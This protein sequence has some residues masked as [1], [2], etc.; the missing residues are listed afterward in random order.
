MPDPDPLPSFKTP[1]GSA[2]PPSGARTDAVPP[3]P[4]PDHTLLRRIG[5]GSYGEVWL[6]RNVLGVYRA[7]KIIHRSSFDHD[8]PFERE[9]AGMQR[10]E[11]VSRSHESQLNILHVGRSPGC[12]YYVMELADDMG[13]GTAID[14]GSYTP[15]NLRSELLLHG[16]LPVDECVRL[17]LALTTALEHLHR[18]G[19]VHRDIKPS[20]IV[21]VNGIPKLAD[22]G[23]VAQAEATMSFVGTE[24]YLPPEGP[25]TVQADVFSLGK[26]LYEIST[27]R[28]RQQFPELPTGITELPD[29]AA[30]AEFNEVLLRAC[31]PDVKQRYE[32]A[33]EMHADLALLQ[34]GKSVARLR[35]V[36]RRLK[37]VGRAGA[38]LAGLAV[39]AGAAFFYQQVQ[40]REARRLASENQALAEENRNRIVR[41][42]IANGVRVL[43][44]GD[45]AG[46]LL[47]FADALPLLANKPAEESIHRIRIQQALNQTPRVLRVFPHESSVYS[48]AFSPEGR[49]VATGTRDGKLRVWNAAEGSLVWG[50]KAMGGR[51][52]FVRFSRDGKRLFASS[53]IE[54][55]AFNGGVGSRNFHAVL[56][57][58]SGREVLPSHEG[59]SGI[60][61][62]VICSHFS[63]DDRWLATAQKDNRIRVFDLADGRLV[64]ELRGH[65]DEVRFLS[66]SA[67]GSLLASASLDRTVRLWRLPSGEPVGLPLAHRM[68]VVRA[69]LAGDGRHIITGSFASPGAFEFATSQAGEGEIQAWDL[70]T[71]QRVGEP[72]KARNWMMMFVNPAQPGRFYAKKH[73]YDF[74]SP[75]EPLFKNPME[76]GAIQSWAFSRDNSRVALGESRNAARIFDATTGQLVAGPFPHAGEVSAIQFSP[77]EKLLL[78]ACGDG[79]A[80]LWDLRPAPTESA[81]R[82]LPAPMQR[83]EAVI[84][85][86]QVGRSPGRTPI[87]MAEEHGPWLFDDQLEPT[88]RL[89]TSEPAMKFRDI[90]S[91]WNS[92]FWISWRFEPDS[93]ALV[94]YRP[95][96]NDL[97]TALLE[98]PDEVTANVL[99]RDDRFI[100]TGCRDGII[101]YWRTSDGGVEKSVA[102]PDAGNGRVHGI[103]PDGRTAI[104][105][106]QNLDERPVF[107]I[108]DLESG[109]FVGAP[110]ALPKGAMLQMRYAPDGKQFAIW[111]FMGAVT[112]METRTGQVI[113]SSIQHSGNLSW[114]EWD[115]DCRRL[116]TA[117]QN[118]EVLVWDVRTGAQLLGPLRTPGGIIRIARWSPD[119][120]FIVTRSDDKKVRVWDA[121]T[122][123]A[124]TPLLRHSGDVAFAFLSR[125]NRLITATHP[126]L[127]RAWDLKESPLSPG[128]LADCAKLLSGR[129]LSVAGTMLV[130]KPEEL[131]EL[132]RSL[133][134]RAPQLFE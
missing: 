63:P 88:L 53:T 128:V 132:N 21:F 61:T 17:G 30:L 45:P 49:F 70:A 95:M 116:L 56:E 111:E 97:R 92:N 60:S 10:F 91:A 38:V 23:L 122:D 102:I 24:G 78:T 13:R 15:R 80:R 98:H 58:E 133:R 55:W 130:L 94:L 19:L 6:A 40:T 71:G 131:A 118:E 18:H 126:D 99:T 120:R 77:D 34:S 33:A 1:W 113:S 25:G 89:E 8:R 84:L 44:E 108:V 81:R 124:V 127:L 125:S 43:D 20:N 100:I 4:I 52:G 65:T 96:G 29:R 104:W 79:N 121:A 86:L 64:S 5:K 117:G 73:A 112:V 123:E 109:K 2:T 68:P 119:G 50:P 9:L 72:I 31:A 114:I 103:C 129:R 42:D 41:L 14:E 67:D 51:V 85:G 69:L 105:V 93:K 46:A 28:D 3:I 87:F 26:V 27:G 110:R 11:P 75:A 37:F 90:R 59:D 54:Q 83:I 32:T 82:T 22:I 16:R 35:T 62:N 12:F 107:R 106:P 7:V 48:S 76:A 66:F 101:R 39:L 134:Q 47:W 36:E 115:P 57:A 74:G